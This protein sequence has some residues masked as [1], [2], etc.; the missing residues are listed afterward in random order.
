MNFSLHD[1]LVSTSTQVSNLLNFAMGYNSFR[2]S[3]Y[4]VFTDADYSYYIVWGDLVKEDNTV[5]GSDVEY[6]HYY[7]VSTS[8]YNS[9]YSYEY[10]TDTDFTLNLGS[11]YYCTSNISEV[12]FV[13]SSALEYEVYD[14]VLNFLVLAV[15]M[16]F[17]IMVKILRGNKA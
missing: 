1:N 12:G 10:G 3:E 11:D 13:N 2:N 9:V 4:V 5:V 8:G 14:N 16:L 15:A 17:A 7:R 6:C